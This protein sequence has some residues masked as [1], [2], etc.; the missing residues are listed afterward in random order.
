MKYVDLKKKK[1]IL[2]AVLIAFFLES[3][4]HQKYFLGILLNRKNNN[5]NDMT[6]QSSY[7]LSHAW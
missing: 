6:K 1:N 7:F 4:Y 5:I 2:M 3:F